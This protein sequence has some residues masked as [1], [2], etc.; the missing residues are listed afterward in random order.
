[1]LA[2]PGRSFSFRIIRRMRSW[3]THATPRPQVSRS[4]FAAVLLPEPEF[5]RK[6]MSRV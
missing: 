2:A 6:T 3:D 1:M 5:P 4:A